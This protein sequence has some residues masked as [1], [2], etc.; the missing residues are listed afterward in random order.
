MFLAEKD[1]ILKNVQGEIVSIE[2]I[3]STAV[4]KL[5]AKPIIDIVVLIPS[6]KNV[7]SYI[8]Q[9][10]NLDYIYRPKRSSVERF[11]FTKNDPPTFHL[12]LAQ[13]DKYSFWKRQ[14]N[15]RD[16]LISHPDIAKKYEKLKMSLI[17][18]YPD[19]RQ[20]YCDGKDKFINN[21]LKL[22]DL[23]TN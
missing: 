9:L 11:F 14:K 6:I 15:F 3:G 8:K 23:N 13:I 10:E 17:K 22:N 5:A 20:E 1:L 21:V 18:K 2:H 4:P 7:D 12:S 19:G 16:F